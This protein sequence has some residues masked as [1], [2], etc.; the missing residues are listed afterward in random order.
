M[1]RYALIFPLCCSPQRSG[2]RRGKRAAVQASEEDVSEDW[3]VVYVTLSP[4]IITDLF[5][6]SKTP[7]KRPRPRPK[8]SNPPYVPSASHRHYDRRIYNPRNYP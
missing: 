7:K 3:Y 8:V 5:L 1:L 2:L 4:L 6:L